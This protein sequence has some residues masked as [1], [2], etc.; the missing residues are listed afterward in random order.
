MCCSP[1]SPS[2]QT[3]RVLCVMRPKITHITLLTL[4]ILTTMVLSDPTNPTREETKQ[5]FCPFGQCEPIKAINPGRWIT[6][7]PN[8]EDSS[9]ISWLSLHPS[10]TPFTYLVFL[11]HHKVLPKE[12]YDDNKEL[13]YFFDLEADDAQM[14]KPEAITGNGGAVL[15]AI[16]DNNQNLVSPKQPK[17]IETH[18]E[19]Q[20]QREEL[21]VGLFLGGPRRYT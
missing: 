12:E 11:K 14:D 13:Y 5:E 20:E 3:L 6:P 9:S 19:E 15:I 1:V 7:G 17:F 16:I 18:Q 10:S 8:S 4:L 2:N 21:R